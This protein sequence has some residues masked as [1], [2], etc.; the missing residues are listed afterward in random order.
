MFGQSGVTVLQICERD[1]W[2][3]TTGRIIKQHSVL[4]YD[5]ALGLM[6]MVLMMC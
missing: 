2:L 4:F 3:P 5:T 6:V 1:C